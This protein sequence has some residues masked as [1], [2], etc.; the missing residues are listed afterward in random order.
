MKRWFVWLALCAGCGGAGT[1]VGNGDAGARSCTATFTGAFAATL[2][3]CDVEVTWASDANAWTLVSDGGDLAGTPYTFAGITF[4][5]T[6]Q[7]MTGTFDVSNATAAEAE[8]TQ[9]T[10]SSPPAWVAGMGSGMTF[11]SLSLSLD[12]LGKVVTTGSGQSVY[13]GSHGSIAATLVD[14][15]PMTAMPDLALSL[16]F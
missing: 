2:A 3:D 4:F 10:G 8:V 13:S 12:S 7:P 9:S 6:G 11:G 16:A 15:N 5:A 1:A 14:Q